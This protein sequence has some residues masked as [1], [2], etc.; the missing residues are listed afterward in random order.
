MKLRRL[1]DVIYAAGFFDGE[2]CIG[3]GRLKCH[4]RATR[5]YRTQV[6]LTQ[7]SKPVILWLRE[8]FGGN[9]ATLHLSG[10]RKRAWQWSAVGRDAEL[11]IIAVLPYL[12]VKRQQALL[13]LNFRKSINA[14]S[15][16]KRLAISEIKMREEMILQMRKLN[17]RGLR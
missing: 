10:N 13:L 17:K 3:I 16:R 6:A 12:K 8:T 5:A 14:N 4:R 2:G 15:G 11:F 1:N 7:A 9:V